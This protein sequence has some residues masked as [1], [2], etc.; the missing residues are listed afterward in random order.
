MDL[1]HVFGFPLWEEATFGVLQRS[2]GEIISIFT[3]YSKSGSAGSGSAKAAMTL[4]MSELTNIALDC[5]LQTDKFKA[6]RINM[7][8]MRAD[9]VDDTLKASRTDK[10]VKEGKGAEAGDKGLE[11]HEV[12]DRRS[13]SG[14]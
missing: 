6:A 12:R 14:P 7:I 2:F 8:F 10:R 4:Q 5:E 11:L 9:Q 3:E 13:N 1:T